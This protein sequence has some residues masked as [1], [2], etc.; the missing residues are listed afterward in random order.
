[1]LLVDGDETKPTEH[2]ALLHECMRPDRKDGLAPRQL[3][4]SGLAIACAQAAGH[5]HR[6]DSEW[7]EQPRKSTSVLFGQK[8]CWRHYRGLVTVLHR[9]QR[10]K[11]RDD[12]LATSHVSLQQ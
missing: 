11:E 2:R 12:R 3:L 7:L 4:S 10:G 1:M 8:L 5:E 6:L 9:Q